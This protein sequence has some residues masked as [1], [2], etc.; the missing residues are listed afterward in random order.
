M[1]LRLGFSRRRSRVAA[2]AAAMGAV[3]IAL[4]GCGASATD[5]ST[6]AVER[7]ASGAMP[8]T[9]TC[10][11]Q[12]PSFTYRSKI[13]NR[14]PSPIMLM[15]GQYDCND[16]S[17]AS[18]PGK[19]FTGKI[20]QPGETLSFSLEPRRNVSRAWTMEFVGV[21]GSP[22]Y[23]TARLSIPVIAYNDQIEVEGSTR[24]RRSKPNEEMSCYLLAMEQTGAPAT[25]E[26]E[27]PKYFWRVSLGLIS[28]GGRVTLASM[29][30]E[31]SVA[32]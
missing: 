27:W 12:S 10:P 17:G 5:A 30:S 9:K 15:A 4:A 11:E 18:T 3:V 8:D 25:P 32:P 7:Q 21:S 23:G 6:A 20:I 29:C 22:S 13:V 31:T 16:W 24:V 28:R 19:V 14:L 2:G 1:P 26:A